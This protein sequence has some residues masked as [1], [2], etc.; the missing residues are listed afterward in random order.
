MR[1]REITDTARQISVTVVFAFVASKLL[2]AAAADGDNVDGDDVDG[3]QD[4]VV[5]GGGG[6]GGGDGPR[7]RQLR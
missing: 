2:A 1:E 6:G 3:D 7:R 5:R 4:S